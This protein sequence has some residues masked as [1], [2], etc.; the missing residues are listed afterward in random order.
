MQSG[1]VSDRRATQA[2]RRRLAAGPADVLEVLEA[3]RAEVGDLIAR[4]EGHVHALLLRQV[5]AGRVVAGGRSAR[6]LT[7]YGLATA[8]PPP[9]EPVLDVVASR[10]R[11]VRETAVA[12]TRRVRDEE[13][14]ERIRADAAA[15]LESLRVADRLSEF[16]SLRAARGVLERVARGRATIVLSRTLGDGLRRLAVHEG[17]WLL[18]VLAAYFLLQAFVVRVY[19]IPSP[20][21]TPTL[22]VGDRVVVWLL[23]RPEVPERWSIVTYR[24]GDDT[25]VKRVVGLPGEEIALRLGDVYADGLLLAKPWDLVAAL[26]APA[27]E[28]DL[29]ALDPAGPT[30]A[31]GPTPRRLEPPV[32]H[33]APDGP[34]GAPYPFALQDGFAVLEGTRA[35]GGRVEL[36]LL[37]RGPEDL[38]PARFRLVLDDAGVRLLEQRGEA[39]PVELARAPDPPLAP[40]PFE[41]ELGYVDGRVSARV[42]GWVHREERRAPYG[43]L[44]P[45]VVL[46]GL[47]RAGRLRLDRDLHYSYDGGI[48]A[49][50]GDGL[51]LNPHRVPEGH[52]FFLGDNTNNSR[53]SRWAEVSDIHVSQVVG[54]VRW[55]AWPPSRIGSPR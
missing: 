44:R 34:G 37:R 27:Y 26:R 10:D 9:G 38:P 19:Q 35:A 49:P 3:L 12:L 53:D 20:S 23:G 13:T 46:A 24:R 29:S 14:R 41:V 6:G 7:R 33:L 4:H 55:R 30:G 40:G 31:P 18:G 39:R 48:G 51:P 54:P 5:R 16:G 15:H 47:T 52:L 1:G 32:A 43:T 25:F 36:E 28:W 21:M 8:A 22:G 2:L 11:G 17:P 45:A 50:S 42:G